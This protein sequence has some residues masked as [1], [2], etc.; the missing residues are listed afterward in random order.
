MHRHKTVFIAIIGLIFNLCFP[1]SSHALPFGIYEPRSL[2]MGGAGVAVATGENAVFYNPAMLATYKKHK[3]DADNESFTFPAISVRGT[4]SLEVLAEQRDR[5][6]Q[7]EITTSITNFNNDPSQQNAQIA[8]DNIGSLLSL[9][10]KIA[11]NPFL[12]DASASLAISVPSKFQG[13]AFFLS[14]RA[15]G[16]GQFNVPASDKATLSA[17]Q[18]ELNSLAQGNAPNYANTDLYDGTNLRDPTPGITSSARARAVYIKELGVSLSRQIKLFGEDYAIGLSPKML[19]VTT[20]EFHRTINNNV[21]DSEGTEDDDWQ[22]NFDLG[23]F[24]KISPNWQAGLTV[25][26]LIE[27]EYPTASGDHITFKPQWRAGVAYLSSSIIYTLDMDLIPNDGVYS[28]NAAQFVL[29]GIE[30]KHSFMRYRLGYRDTI[31]HKGPR[32]VGVFSAG[33]GFNFKPVYLDLAYSENHQQ[34]AASLM[35]GFNF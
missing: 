15:V 31:A 6:Y 9:V 34:R 11:N 5:N 4:R 7:A 22:V 23:L 14:H 28:G 20:Y 10:D 21:E 19:Q 33:L 1:L 27:R 26:N 32:E 12:L 13:G 17:Y 29:A 24:K 2:A 3:E 35:F 18:Q 16:D 8:A 25:K 30:I